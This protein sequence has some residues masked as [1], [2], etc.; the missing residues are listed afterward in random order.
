MVGNSEGWSADISARAL[1]AMSRAG[2]DVLMFGQSFVEKTISLL[3]R[4]QDAEHA[5]RVLQREF[6]EER[7][8]KVLRDITVQQPVASVSVVGAAADDS[9]SVASR[10][11]AALSKQR[12]HI[13]TIARR[14]RSTTSLSSCLR[15]RWTTRYA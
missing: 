14:T 10:S 11:F 6:E 9:F 8:Q 13:L 2:V 3:V 5:L 12:A 1:T 7:Q 15:Q 4:G